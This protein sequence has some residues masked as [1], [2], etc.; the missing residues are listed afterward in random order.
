VK[1][2]E[3]Q[4]LQT[5]LVRVV[6]SALRGQVVENHYSVESVA[7]MLEVSE[8]TVWERIAQFERSGGKEGLGP[9]VKLSHKV[10]RIPASSVN[11]LLESHRVQPGKEAVA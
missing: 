9:I 4:R 11:R 6:D 1:E 5:R 7:K 8:R 10:V 3:I 2:D